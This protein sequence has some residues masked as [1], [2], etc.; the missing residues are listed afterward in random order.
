MWSQVCGWRDRERG[1]DTDA[2]RAEKDGRGGVE[3]VIAT[4]FW[5]LLKEIGPQRV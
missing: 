2:A 3:A 4:G 1:A 5:V